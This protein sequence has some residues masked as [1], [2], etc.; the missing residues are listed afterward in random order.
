MAIRKSVAKAAEIT[1]KVIENCGVVA[2]RNNGYKLELRYMSWDGG[3]E[4]YDLRP[5]KKNDDGTEKCGKGITLS[6]DELEALGKL[7]K[8]MED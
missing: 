4:R 5:W 7:I 3:E 6:G 2:E 8:E 1:Y